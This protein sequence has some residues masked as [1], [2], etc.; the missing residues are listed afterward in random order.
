[1]ANDKKISELPIAETI[2]TSDRSILISNNADYQFDFATLLQFINSGLN[3]GANLTF[4]PVLPQNTSGK[5]GDV[6]I[7]TSAGSFVQKI[8]GVWTVVY[9]IA[10]GGSTDTTVL[11]GTTAPTTTTGNNG[12]TFINTVS[13]IFYKKTGGAWGQV[14]S[15]QT[16]PQGPQGTSGTNGTNGTNGKTILNG[17]TNPANSL[18]TDGDFYINTASYYL[19]GPKNAGVWGTGISLIVSGVQFEETDNKNTP[20]GY[21][22]LDGSGKIA[23]AQLPSY[24]DDV[25]EV[26]NYASLPVTGE[27][28]KIYITTDTN[29]EYR[30]SGSAYIQIVAS[31][32]TT[33]AVPEGTTNKYFTLSRVLNTILTGIGFGSSTAISATDSILQALG[34]L[35][36]QITGLF[37]IPTGGTSGQILAKNSNSDGDLHWINAPSG[38]GSGG[39]SEPSGQIKSFRVD[40]GAVGD[41]VTD[42]TV[43]V[44]AALAA[45]AVIFDTGDFLVT[46]LINKYGCKILGGARILQ[47]TANMAQQINTAYADLYPMVFGEEYLSSFHKKLIAKTATTI[48]LSGDSTT[49]GVGSTTGYDPVSV[50]KDLTARQYVQSGVTYINNGQSGK[51]S[52]DWLDTYLAVDLAANPDVLI[53]RWGINDGWIH[54]GTPKDII[55]RLDTGLST[56]RANSNFT[57]DKLAIIL[58]SQNTTQDDDLDHRGQLWNEE[59]N[60]GLRALARKYQC[61]FMDIYGMFQDSKSSSDY[62]LAYSNGNIHP[63][64]AFYVEIAAKTFEVL[65]PIFYR[66]GGVNNRGQTGIANA[67]VPS[68]YPLGISLD[69]ALISDGFPVNGLM[70]TTRGGQNGNDQLVQRLNNY[71]SSEAVEY[72][73]TGFVSQGNAF[74]DWVK[75]QKVVS[76]S[77]VD[78]AD[79]GKTPDTPVSNYIFGVSVDFVFAGNGWPINGMLVT[80]KGSYGAALSTIQRLTSYQG[81]A[82][83][84]IRVG[85]FD[86]AGNHG[87]TDFKLVN[88]TIPVQYYFERGVGETPSTA[89]P[90]SYTN[91]IT[92]EYATSSQGFPINGLLVTTKH[93]QVARQELTSTPGA[94]AVMYIR[95]GLLQSGGSWQNWK[96]VTVS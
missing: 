20:N 11:Y 24:V 21:A 83:E 12:D 68:T 6:F 73:R 53:L 59:L 67:A 61:C 44:N 76:P 27:T 72:F 1:M 66:N 38:G 43:A 45:N 19:F 36:A 86:T 96:Q 80:T 87:W 26:A 50:L 49:Y 51:T 25:L 33:D 34:K 77:Y 46:N 78:S 2:N 9:T 55:D 82:I 79:S 85:S 81:S 62:L 17:T 31:P 92:I 18:G 70:F 4:G 40:Y 57:Q 14:F 30:W 39:S 41:G 91:G 60:N 3:A 63:K 16:G 69:F 89:L 95:G 22:G 64:N 74:T 5:N 23:S 10:A 65:F 54:P 94:E 13:G 75:V 58:Q 88:T 71:G 8:S 93:S 29:N 47:Q 28:G 56:I 48:V 32:G 15:M 7:N 37:K 35:Q 84:Y 42:D 52:Q 90:N